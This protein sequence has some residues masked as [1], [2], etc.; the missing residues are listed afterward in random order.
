M[1]KNVEEFL[2]NSS[3]IVAKDFCN[4]IDFI[5]D[6]SD[7]GVKI[8]SPIEKL[9]YIALMVLQKINNLDEWDY[10]FNENRTDLLP[11]CPMLGLYVVPQFKI[12]NYRVD[13]RISYGNKKQKY[14]EAL[15]ELDSQ[16]FHE[17]NEKERRYEKI[18]ERNFVK[19]GYKILRFTGKEINDNPYIIAQEILEY[20]TEEDI[21]IP[22]NLN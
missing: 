22:E 8:T 12:D 9:L 10:N 20:L 19:L 7:C 6:D 15:I 17:R 5:F 14:K 2:E 1:E 13:F 11:H 4:C 21:M 16:E 3:N 18:R